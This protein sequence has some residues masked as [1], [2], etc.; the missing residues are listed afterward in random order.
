MEQQAPNKNPSLQCPRTSPFLLTHSAVKMQIP[1]S[2]L[3]EHGLS[4]VSTCDLVAFFPFCR[5]RVYPYPILGGNDVVT[6]IIMDN[7]M[8]YTNNDRNVDLYVD[9][10]PKGNAILHPNFIAIAPFG[11]P[12][13]MNLNGKDYGKKKYKW[14]YAT[15]IFTHYTRISDN[16]NLWFKHNTQISCIVTF[17]ERLCMSISKPRNKH[18]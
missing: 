7:V 13:P 12:Q 16:F 4:E 5:L 17:K 2:S 3:I 18:T 9:E 1:G 11:S 8:K 15:L 14:M 10:R 6:S